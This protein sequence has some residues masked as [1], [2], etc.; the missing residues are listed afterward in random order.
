MK[1]AT[2]TIMGDMAKMGGKGKNW[3]KSVVLLKLNKCV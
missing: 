3:K 1:L 2:K